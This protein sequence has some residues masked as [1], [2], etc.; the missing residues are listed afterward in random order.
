MYVVPVHI[1]QPISVVHIRWPLSSNK[2]ANRPGYKAQKIQGLATLT[3]RRDCTQLSWEEERFSHGCNK[4]KGVF[5]YCWNFPPGQC[6]CGQHSSP[7]PWRRGCPWWPPSAWTAGCQTSWPAFCRRASASVWPREMKLFS[8]ANIWYTADS[9]RA[10]CTMQLAKPGW[11]LPQQ[12][13]FH[14]FNFPSLPN[15]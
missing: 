9:A 7:Y 5:L 6:S 11:Q 1:F 15:E 13:S 3:Q 14:R 10:S 2:L 4:S 8:Y 12:P